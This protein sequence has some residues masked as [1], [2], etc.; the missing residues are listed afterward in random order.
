MDDSNHIADSNELSPFAG[1]ETEPILEAVP[2]AESHNNL[3]LDPGYLIDNRYRIDG[4]IGIGGYAI[5]YKA[6]HLPLDR[7]VAIKVMKLCEETDASFAERFIRE[8]K[9]AAK[10]N[11]KNSV[12][13]YDYGVI[14]E[15]GQPYIVMELLSGHDLYDEIYTISP[16]GPKRAYKLFRPV[17]DALADGHRLGIV[18]KDLKP[19]NLFIANPETPGECMKVLDFGVA[20]V[21]DSQMAR[22][23]VNGEVTGT[24]R[25]LAPE[26]IISQTVSPAIDVYQ[27]AL[28]ISEAITGKPSVLG[29]P[30]EAM[31]CHCHGEIKMA[32]FLMKGKCRPVFLK[33]IAA[34]PKKRY[35]N[36]V[37]F[38]EALDSIKD[39]FDASVLINRSVNFVSQSPELDDITDTESH[40]IQNLAV[41]APSPL[42]PEPQPALANQIKTP[43]TPTQIIS[44]S[45]N[46]TITA[47]I[48]L[49]IVMMLVLIG[50]VV[51]Y[52][53][54]ASNHAPV[55][56]KTIPISNTVNETIASHELRLGSVPESA[57][58]I[59]RETHEVICITPCLISLTDAELPFAAQIHKDGFIDQT[60]D[61]ASLDEFI[62][63]KGNYNITLKKSH[64]GT[65]RYSREQISDI[66][67]NLR[68]FMPDTNDEKPAQINKPARPPKPTHRATDS[69][70]NEYL[71]DYGGRGV[72]ELTRKH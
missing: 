56:D 69:N 60:L 41:S 28:I 40:Q 36:C 27:M 13:I 42:N 52:M 63:A 8:A 12:T 50:L 5:V 45:G 54:F 51:Y 70:S 53:L 11:H 37:E 62:A 24:P 26:Y 64:A 38:G 15:S 1:D 10:L 49:V 29:N 58:V 33:A 55:Q 44:E 57:A 32:D 23:T 48:I 17:I 43:E 66:W 68:D 14:P 47:I 25:F 4:E 31:A 61:I 72:K 19:E 3:K 35:Q 71:N 16:I 21:N 30:I 59:K 6:R 46:R 2:V 39:E 9:I 20:R 7:D 22:L 67:K 65:I 18:H 34:D